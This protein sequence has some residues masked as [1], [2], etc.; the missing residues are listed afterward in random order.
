MTEQVAAI[1]TDLK[2]RYPRLRVAGL[3]SKRLLQCS[4]SVTATMVKC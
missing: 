1:L 4:G 3:R 2:Q